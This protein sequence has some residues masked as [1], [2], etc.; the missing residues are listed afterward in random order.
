MVVP[1]GGRG[2]G[3]IIHITALDNLASI[4]EQGVIYSD[5]TGPDDL[6]ID[7]LGSRKV[8]SQRA[9][10]PVDCSA[11]GFVGE[12]VPFYFSAR[13]PMLYFAHTRNPLSPFKKGQKELVHLVS[14]VADVAA[15][16][17]S[18]VITDRNAALAYARQSDDLTHLDDLVDWTLQH[19]K[20]W[21]DTDS[22]PDRMER[23]MCEF[24]VH[25]RLPVDSLIGLAVIDQATTNR[26]SDTLAG[27]DHPAVMV[28]S[29]WYY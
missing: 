12:Y 4:W 11:G 6:P 27:Y 22:E 26:V 8:K 18:Y 28:K 14:H 10:Q 1:T 19:Q 17:M 23:R 15:A 3:Y 9:A 16:A 25:D 20:R 5:V 7:E 13:S 2:R 29:R 21:N 24:L